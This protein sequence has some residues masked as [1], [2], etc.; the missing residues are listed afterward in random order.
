M[1]THVKQNMRLFSKWRH[2]KRDAAAAP[3]DEAAARAASRNEDGEAAAHHEGTEGG[4]AGAMHGAEAHEGGPLDMLPCCGAG[5]R[6]TPAAASE[7]AAEGGAPG[8]G[9]AAKGGGDIEKGDGED[10]ARYRPFDEDG[11][12][13]T[14]TTSAR[15]PASATVTGDQPRLIAELI[16]LFRRRSWKKKLFTGLVASSTLLVLL[17]LLLGWGHVSSFLAAFLEWM[18]DHP[19]L[20]VWA[21]VAA[22]ATAS[23][24][25]VPPS[26]LV[27]AAGFTCQALWGGWGVP[28]ALV[29]SF[30]E[31]ARTASPSGSF[32][33]LCIHGMRSRG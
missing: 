6:G 10:P 21:Y 16:Q 13:K 27:F 24:V 19:L 28:I 14:S 29:A 4:G 8:Q 31:L 17:D 2:A 25:F 20:G 15:G 32:S 3:A 26:P 30:R 18:A 9:S 12:E 11:G 22:L 5:G 7:R 33:M 1:K 23:L